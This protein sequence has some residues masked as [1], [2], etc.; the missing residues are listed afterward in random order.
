LLAAIA[1]KLCGAA[2]EGDAK[3][4]NKLVCEKVSLF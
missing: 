2:F 1:K 3:R 4:K